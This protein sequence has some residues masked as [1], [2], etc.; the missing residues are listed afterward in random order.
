M[1]KTVKKKPNVVL[2][3]L[4]MLAIFAFI[5]EVVIWGYGSSLIIKAVENHPQG[6]LVIREAVLASLVLIVMLLFGNS[7]VFTQKKEKFFKGFFYGLYYVIGISFFLLMSG[8]LRGALFTGGLAVINLIIG[9]FLIGVAEE[10]L[11]RGWLLNEFLERY[12]DT[13]KGVWFS[14]IISG[15]IFG[16][17]HLGNIGGMGQSVANTITQAL[18]AAAT[19][20]MFGLIY[21][22]TKNIWTVVAIHGLWDFSIFLGELLPTASMAETITSYSIIGVIFSVLM[23]GAELLNVIPYVKDIDKEPKKGKVVM[24][25]L[26]SIVLFYVF[27]IIVSFANTNVG[28]T[29]IFG[30]INIKN[31][32]VTTDNYSNYIINYDDNAYKFELY[33]KDGKLILANSNTNYEVE[34]DTTRLQGYTIFEDKDYYLLAYIDF[35]DSTNIYLKYFYMYKKDLANDNEYL[36]KIRDN[37]NKYMLPEAGTIEIIHDRDSNL[38]FIGVY[39]KDKGRYLLVDNKVVHLKEK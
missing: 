33:K 7:Y 2:Y 14:I 32:S 26:I 9:C 22:K 28:K 12:G 10:F 24:F 18:S 34:L 36:D 35:K 38:N 16:L 39:S 27:T 4:I 31:Y 3:T 8:V 23:V 20:I 13:K 37:M 19:G 30:N 1:N 15:I 17:I 25:A 29:Y 6:T 11:C 5:S 21:Y